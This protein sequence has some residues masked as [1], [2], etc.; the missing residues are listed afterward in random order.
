VIPLPE[1]GLEFVLGLGS[2]LFAA[3]VLVLLRPV[4]TRPRPGRARP[5]RV[6]SKRRVY[7]NIAIGAVV[8]AWALASLIAKA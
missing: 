3:N 4:V 1:L 6:P 7:V 8:A 2:A 5:A